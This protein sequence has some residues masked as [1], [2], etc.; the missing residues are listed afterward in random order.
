VLVEFPLLVLPDVTALLYLPL[1]CGRAS[2][3]ASAPGSSLPIT[4][5]QSS[6]HHDVKVKAKDTAGQQQ[7][8]RYMVRYY[9]HYSNRSRGMRKQSEASDRTS[10]E[11]QACRITPAWLYCP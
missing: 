4:S 7:L 6:V 2:P 1:T 8:A 11:F 5:M 3:S 9:G 10:P